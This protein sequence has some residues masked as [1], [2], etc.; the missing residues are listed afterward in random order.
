MPWLEQLSN[1]RDRAFYTRRE[2]WRETCQIGNNWEAE[3]EVVMLR[4][5][6]GGGGPAL[7]ENV[8]FHLCP[9]TLGMTCRKDRK[10]EEGYL[11]NW[12]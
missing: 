2:T 4:R 5:C 12:K 10:Q 6:H 11:K 9:E 1:V 8:P 3:K 7:L